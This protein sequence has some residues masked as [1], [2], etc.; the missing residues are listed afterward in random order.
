VVH[1]PGAVVG[2][3]LIDVSDYVCFYRFD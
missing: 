2:R 1:G 3:E